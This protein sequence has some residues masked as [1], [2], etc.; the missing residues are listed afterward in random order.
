VFCRR[1]IFFGGTVEIAKS[2]AFGEYFLQQ[3]TAGPYVWQTQLQLSGF[4]F[5]AIDATSVFGFAF[6]VRKPETQM[7]Q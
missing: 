1:E 6:T 5:G 3:L 7:R 4:W 2:P